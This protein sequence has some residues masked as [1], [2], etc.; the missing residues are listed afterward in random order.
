MYNGA[1]TTNIPVTELQTASRPYM[2][3]E[4]KLRYEQYELECAW[5]NARSKRNQL[6]KQSDW[7]MIEGVPLS[8][9]KKQQWIEYR[10]ALRNIPQ[11]FETADSIIWPT[12]PQ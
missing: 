3:E 9:E 4:Q 5:P 7:T 10:Q 6:L 2:T 11:V 12:P 8:E 1:S